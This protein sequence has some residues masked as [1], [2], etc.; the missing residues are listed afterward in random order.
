[1]RGLFPAPA[2]VSV[3]TMSAAPASVGVPAIRPSTRPTP[4]GSVAPSTDPAVL[5]DIGRSTASPTVH[6][7]AGS[8]SATSIGTGGASNAIRVCVKNGACPSAPARIVTRT[9]CAAIGAVSSVAT[10][11][12]E[13]RIVNGPRAIT[14][15]P[16]RYRSASSAVS[17]Q[18]S[19]DADSLP[20][21][22]NR[23]W[24]PSASVAIS[25]SIAAWITRSAS[26]ND[27]M[28]ARPASG[29]AAPSASRNRNARTNGS[30]AASTKADRSSETVNISNSGKTRKGIAA[31]I[32]RGDPSR[33]AAPV[34]TAA[35][36]SCRAA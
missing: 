30:P 1:M 21:R 20:S 27:R 7:A 34:G 32:V 15:R 36:R 31:A 26:W 5:P 4:G 19:S 8:D 9:P 29:A 33:P 2:S 11:P 24:S 35:R 13:G 22:T 17:G 18:P 12:A 10:S 23:T 16:C 6:V 28:K 14:S 25:P 3:S